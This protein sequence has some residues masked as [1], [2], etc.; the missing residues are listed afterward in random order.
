MD[1]NKNGLIL[2]ILHAAILSIVLLLKD[3][4]KI[5]LLHFFTKAFAIFY[6][7][8]YLHGYFFYWCFLCQVIP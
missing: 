5:D 3:Q 2:A 6:Q 4:I 1:L 8:H 7:Y